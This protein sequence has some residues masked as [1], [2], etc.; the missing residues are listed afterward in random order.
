MMPW[1]WTWGRRR[2][3]RGLT[4]GALAAGAAALPWTAAGAGDLALKRVMLSTG[5][6]AY[7]EYEAK[8]T[9]DAALSLDVRLDRVDDVLKS[10]VVYDDHGGIGTISLPGKEPLR[11]VFREMPFGPDALESPQALLSAL[12]GAE[13][14]AVGSRTIA[15]RVLSVTEDNKTLP[16]NGGV[17]TRHRLA[18]MTPADRLMAAIA[19][20]LF[21][22]AYCA[23]EC[24]RTIARRILR[25]G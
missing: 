11:E 25:D 23:V 15:G 4:L 16:N 14:K 8:V 13:V 24:L 5:G 18:L 21:A 10:I 2:A 7:V 19:L 22:P 3:V 1:S 12:R 9:G 6:V 17:V 20:A